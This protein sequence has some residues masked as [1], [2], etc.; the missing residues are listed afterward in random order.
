MGKHTWGTPTGCFDSQN[1]G[2]YPKKLTLRSSWTSTSF[3][4][5]HF[6]GRQ[7]ECCIFFSASPLLRKWENDRPMYTLVY[8]DVRTESRFAFFNGFSVLNHEQLFTF[9]RAELATELS[10]LDLVL[11]DPGKQ[12]LWTGAIA[13]KIMVGEFPSLRVV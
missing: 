9:R 6:S 7:Q 2:R 3:V 4:E 12:K 1:I 5:D 8:L 13:P 11:E 10:Q